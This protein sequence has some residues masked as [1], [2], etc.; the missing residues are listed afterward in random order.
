MTSHQSPPRKPLSFEATLTLAGSTGL[1]LS[2][3]KQVVI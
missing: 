1:G 3:E 2:E